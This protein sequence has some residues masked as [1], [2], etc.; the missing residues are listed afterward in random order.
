MFIPFS[1]DEVKFTEFGQDELL[2]ENQDT[3]VQDC[4]KCESIRSELEQHYDNVIQELQCEISDLKKQ[5]SEN[6]VNLVQKIENDLIKMQYKLE[7]NCID[8]SIA[9]MRSAAPLVLQG[10]SVQNVMKFIESVMKDFNICDIVSINVHPDMESCI[11]EKFN[12]ITIH[13]DE[14]LERFDCTVRYDD[15]EL[16]NSLSERM[17][18]IELVCGKI[19]VQ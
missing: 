3:K 18:N 6:I 19:N 12:Q 16:R 15:T 5:I 10:D 1:N 2:E 8:L 11:K 7:M 4:V 9:M 13:K 17:R 14:S